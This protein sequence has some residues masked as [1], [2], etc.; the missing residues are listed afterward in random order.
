MRQ[1]DLMRYYPRGKGKGAERP[2]ITEEDKRISKQF[3]RDYFDGDRRHGYGGYN[4]HPR[5]WTDTVRHI[6]DVYQ[7]PDDASVLDIGC[8][9]G[10]MLYD[11]MQLLPK[12]RLAGID[13]SSYAIENALE[14]VRPLVQ[15]GNARSL[16]FPDKSFDL[17]LAINT[18]HNLHHDECRQSLHEIQR[19]ARRHAFV[20]VDGY[21][22]GEQPEAR[23]NW[24]LTAGRILPVED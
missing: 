17:V 16:P 24:V 3:G 9:K 21:R 5:F 23:I 1:I 20:M 22:P 10:F 19:V 4:Y 12:A 14:S 6:R 13:I 8:A 11:F 18:I 7:L 15:A 2:V